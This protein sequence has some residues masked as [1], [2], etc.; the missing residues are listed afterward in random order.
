MKSVRKRIAVSALLLCLG[1]WTGIPGA[2][3]ARAGDTWMAKIALSELER[4]AENGEFDALSARV[5][6]AIMGRLSTGK[7][8]D[9]AAMTDLIYVLR[10]CAYGKVAMELKFEPIDT[11]GKPKPKAARAGAFKDGKELFKWLV[12]N[13]GLSRLLFRGM[14]D[15]S[16]PADSLKAVARLKGAGDKKLLA[17]A[18]L[19]TAFATSRAAGPYHEQP[20]PASLSEAFKYY[21]TRKMRYDLKTMPY[22]LSRYLADTKISIAERLWAYGKYNRYPNPAKAYFDLRYDTAHFVRGD[23]KKISRLAFTLAN[24]RKVGGVCIEQAYY[25]AEVCKALGI[26]AKIVSGRSGEGIHHAWMMCFVK[27]RSSRSAAWDS[28][29]GR[30]PEQKYYVGDVQNPSNGMKLLD[31]ELML[32]GAAALLPLAR[33][34]D[35]DTATSLAVLAADV[36][37]AAELADLKDLQALAALHKKRFGTAPLDASTKA[38]VKI[39]M[40]I[41][42]EF[43]AAALSY[44]LAHR[45]AWEFIIELRKSRDMLEVSHLGKFFDVLTSKTAKMY[46]DY[47]CEMVLRIVP[48]L[49]EP[50]GRMKVYQKALGVYASRPDL[51]GRIMIACGDDYAER[52]KPASALKF[53]ETAALRNVE[54]ADI[55]TVASGKAETLLVDAGHTKPAIA[56]YTRLFKAARKPRRSSSVFTGQTSYYILG[57]RLATLL[58]TAGQTKDAQKIRTMIKR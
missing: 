43:L 52:S 40:T 53:Y 31:C 11:K 5:K 3:T 10:A 13:R 33:R 36:A 14:Q 23:P 16:E 12:A 21:T 20:N 55:V 45:R 9:F 2:S 35:A 32:E 30:Y 17:F 51:Q 42:E 44:N 22:E 6:G 28:T 19:V 49:P 24:L 25:S 7:V 27:K 34:E 48:S 26:P 1:A 8:R 41:V 50:K 15:V 18:E 46:P 54:L 29:T 47:S 58:E 37:N 56:M 57:R 39:D 38:T 4:S